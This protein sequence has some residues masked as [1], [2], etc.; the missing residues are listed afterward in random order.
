MG[1]LLQAADY[2]LNQLI[3]LRVLLASGRAAQFCHALDA[4]MFHGM[5]YTC[6]CPEPVEFPRQ[7]PI[8]HIAVQT[9]ISAV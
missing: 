7:I 2:R 5:S 9:A 8:R 6:C 4:R 1:V 3:A